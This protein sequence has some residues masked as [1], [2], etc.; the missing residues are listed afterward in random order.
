VFKTPKPKRTSLEI[1]LAILRTAKK[2]PVVGSV[3]DLARKTGV[4]YDDAKHWLEI[5]S[6]IVKVGVL[7]ILLEG[8][9]YVVLEVETRNIPNK[10]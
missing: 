6:A 10:C 5:F 3:W 1:A 7:P 8:K 9:E 4:D 2:C